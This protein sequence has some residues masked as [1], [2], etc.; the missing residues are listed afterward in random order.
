MG[1]FMRPGFDNCYIEFIHHGRRI[2]TSS[3]TNNKAKARAIEAK[4]RAELLTGDALASLPKITF[5]EAIARYI[6]AVIKPKNNAKVLNS[7][8]YLLGRLKRD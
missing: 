8:S 2:K 7:D 4:M 5:G 3:A 1:V 6:D